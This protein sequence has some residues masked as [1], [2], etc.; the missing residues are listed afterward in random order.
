MTK[1]ITEVT[2]TFE[3]E[4]GSVYKQTLSGKEAKAW[5]TD[6]DACIFMSQAHGLPLSE[7]PWVEE[8]LPMPKEHPDDKC[9]SKYAGWP[10]LVRVHKDKPDEDDWEN[11]YKDVAFDNDRFVCKRCG[12]ESRELSVLPHQEYCEC[13]TQWCI[14]PADDQG[15]A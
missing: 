4:D 9:D 2:M 1:T 12:W 8:E 13:G 15:G 11:D 14:Y 3:R 5:Q 7:H 6:V 10:I